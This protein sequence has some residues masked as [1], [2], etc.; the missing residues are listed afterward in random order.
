MKNGGGSALVSSAS[1][2][3]RASGLM[4]VSAARSSIL[5]FTVADDGVRGF[6]FVRQ[7][8][9]AQIGS[10]F[11]ASVI[12][13]CIPIQRAYNS[14]KN[15]KHEFLNRLACGVLAVEDGSVDVDLLEDEGLAPGRILIYRNGSA[16]P[17]FLDPGSLP[18][19][20]SY[21]EE[22]LLSEFVTVSGVSELMRDS[23]V[24]SSVSSGTALSLLIEQDETRLSV[25]A[26]YIRSAV[27]EIAE[28]VVRLYKQ[29]ADAKR[30]SRIVDENG[31][32]EIYYW[33]K[34]IDIRCI[35]LFHDFYI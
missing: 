1:R 6:P 14:V 29:F 19:D 20:F 3:R 34:S 27:K 18:S 17:R 2:A 21:E 7:V 28:H 30:L 16:A 12:E 23:S 8:S 15:R 31:D 11:G 5:T 22:K 10:F 32:I 26:E 24:P 35:M 9:I 25:S 13:R 33:D 4:Q